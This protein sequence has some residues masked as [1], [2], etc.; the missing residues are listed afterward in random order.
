VQQDVEIVGD[1]EVR[2]LE[3]TGERYDERD[4]VAVLGAENADLV[5]GIVQGGCIFGGHGE[6]GDAAG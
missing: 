4:V 3:D 6:G 2:E 1:V 5:V